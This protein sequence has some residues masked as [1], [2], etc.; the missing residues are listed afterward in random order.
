MCY[1]AVNIIVL[2]YNYSVI[3][4]RFD[5]KNIDL[6]ANTESDY[7]Y[8]RVAMFNELI[9]CRDSMPCLSDDSFSSNDVEHFLYTPANDIFALFSF[10]YVFFVTF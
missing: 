8:N 2:I 10:F 4:N 3:S 1:A 9:Q 5:I 6:T 7:I